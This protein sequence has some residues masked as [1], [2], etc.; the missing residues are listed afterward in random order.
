MHMRTLILVAAGVLAACVP[1]AA[2]TPPAP[3]ASPGTVRVLRVQ[4]VMRT[5]G[6]AFS[7][8]GAYR[9]IGRAEQ[10]GATGHL[11]E[12]A[13]THY[14]GAMARYGKNDGTGAAM[15][16]RLATDL[17]RAALDERPVP[18]PPTPRDLPAPP[19]LPSMPGSSGGGP[20]PMMPGMPGPGMPGVR[21]LSGD[22][23]GG[24]FHPM[25]GFRMHGSHGF[26]A[27]RLAEVMKVETSAEAKQLA[28]AAVDANAAAQRAALAGNV[29]EATRQTRLSADLMSAVSALAAL[30]HP[31]LH[32]S[33]PPR[34]GAM[35]GA[36]RP[37]GA[38]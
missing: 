23:P 19:A 37:P 25:G 14:R 17:A 34:D 5:G 28:Q 36:P 15:E 29:A 31:E 11:V 10:A 9:E 7:L 6:A 30:N 4:S 12:A 32:P 20:G 33:M 2:Q 22:G 26:D 24:F 1:A 35:P 16:A 8:N 27:I 38:Q 3:A 21:V 13:R 18:P